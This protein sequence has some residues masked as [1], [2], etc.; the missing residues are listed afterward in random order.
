MCFFTTPIR[1]IRH[2]EAK[3]KYNFAAGYFLCIFL[4]YSLRSIV[5]FQRKYFCIFVCLQIFALNHDPLIGVTCVKISHLTFA[6][7]PRI[8][9]KTD[10]EYLCKQKYPLRGLMRGIVFKFLQY[11]IETGVVKI[12]GLQ[13]RKHR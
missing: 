4:Q 11:L 5:E 12:N 3:Q 8:M 10:P 9:C 7:R 13:I 2:P 1:I 6:S